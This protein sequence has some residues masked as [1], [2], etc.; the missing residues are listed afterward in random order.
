MIGVT[1]AL[2]ACSTTPSVSQPVSQNNKT[3]TGAAPT[4]ESAASAALQPTPSTTVADIEQLQREAMAAG[5]FVPATKIKP[6]PNWTG[7]DLDGNTWN[8]STLTGKT[9][10]VN[11]W[12]SWCGPC[13]NEWPI[14]QQASNAH[15]NIRFIGIN[16]QD[17]LDKARSWVSN[18]PTNYLHIFDERAVMK[19]SLTTVP[20]RGMPI[21]VILNSNG[22]ITYWFSGE[23]SSAAL[24]KILS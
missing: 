9:T 21:T 10:V 7:T 23:I 5:E 18:N 1:L 19:A 12:A 13:R 8:S 4:S 2:A 11:F 20:N 24:E 15:P 14:L 17:S 3:A 6:F 22:E 16:T